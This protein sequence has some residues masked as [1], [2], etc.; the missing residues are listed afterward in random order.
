MT[1]FNDI[2]ESSDQITKIYLLI[3]T[4]LVALETLNSVST[5][6][7]ALKTIYENF[8]KFKKVFSAQT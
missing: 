7:Y 1:Y 5:H 3:T 4:S 6:I 2:G 8:I